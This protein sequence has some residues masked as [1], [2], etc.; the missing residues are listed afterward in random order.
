MSG[1]NNVSGTRGGR[2]AGL[3][4][5]LAGCGCTYAGLLFFA[6]R[7]NYPAVALCALVTLAVLT[8]ALLGR[9][10]FVA[11]RPERRWFRWEPLVGVRLLAFLYAGTF[12]LLLTEVTGGDRPD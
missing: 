4:A 3:W 2:H 5:V 8:T 9:L 10:L 7:W 6:V 11:G 12:P 1:L